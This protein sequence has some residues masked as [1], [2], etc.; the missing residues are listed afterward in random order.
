MAV[1]SAIGIFDSG[2]G[3][4]STAQAIRQLLPC[5]DLIYVADSAN[6]PYGN[7]S[8]AFILQRSSQIIE[9]LQARK[10]KAIVVAC[11]TATVSAIAELRRHYSLPII[12][13]EPGVKPATELSR[14]GVVGVL[15]T[16]QTLQSSS[17]SGLVS[18]FGQSSH[19]EL[20]ACPGLVE[21]VEKLDLGGVET[22]ALLRRY[23]EP[24]L[25]KG[26][27]KIVLGCTH[28]AFLSPLIEQIIAGRASIINTN[29]A[30]AR[31]VARRLQVAD[32]LAIEKRAGNSY[33]YSNHETE[34]ASAVISHFWGD[35]VEVL[36]F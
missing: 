31:E 33:F 11:N 10:V 4:L 12:G 19:V 25:A 22:E 18:R 20:Q 32:L 13:M 9:F 17:F 29:S 16:V 27:D 34:K 8:Q 1:S 6:A 5:E 36:P 14:S 24:L 23:L 35:K 3:G 30:V 7:K 26:A 21:Q 2:V 28:Y 15:A